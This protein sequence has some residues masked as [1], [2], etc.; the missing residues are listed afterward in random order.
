MEGD[1]VV[2]TANNNAVLQGLLTVIHS[3]VHEA[4]EESHVVE[5]DLPLLTQQDVEAVKYLAGK[6]DIDFLALTFT[7]SGDDV[8]EA[9]SFLEGA[10]LGSTK[11]LAKVWM[12]WPFTD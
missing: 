8:R 1:D 12:C 5:A 3:R 7:R 10:G 6:F 4:S 11:I 9:R 2:C